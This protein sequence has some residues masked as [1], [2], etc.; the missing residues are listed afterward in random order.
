M[1]TEGQVENGKP[2]EEDTTKNRYLTFEIDNEEYAIGIIN[3]NEIITMSAIT[4]VP[5]TPAYVKGIINLR[6]EIIPVIDVRRRFMKM[7]KEYDELTCIVVIEYSGYV[8]GLIVDNVKAVDYIPE[9]DVA[10]PPNAKLNHY[11]QYIRN[12]GRVG[13]K[14]KLFLDLDKFLLQNQ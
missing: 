1:A 13:D 8:L 7:E 11:N 5:E 14:V 12:I 9:E 3:V 2:I 10:P 6:G 4:I